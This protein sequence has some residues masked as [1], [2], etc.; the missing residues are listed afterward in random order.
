MHSTLQS[1]TRIQSESCLIDIGETIIGST[2][3][4]DVKSSSY[5]SYQRVGGGDVVHFSSNHIQKGNEY[6]TR[7]SLAYQ[8]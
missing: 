6:Q 2:N 8:M 4:D 1:A 7:L 3:N 5:D